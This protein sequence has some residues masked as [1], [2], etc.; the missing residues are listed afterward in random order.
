M[1]E[2]TRRSYDRFLGKGATYIF[3]GERVDG[4][5]GKKKAR[6]GNR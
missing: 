2:I 4:N 5:L 1:Q 3:Y 6:K